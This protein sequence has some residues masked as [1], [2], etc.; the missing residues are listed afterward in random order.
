MLYDVGTLSAISYPVMRLA[1]HIEEGAGMNDQ[2]KTR[3]IQTKWIG[4]RIQTET[5]V[6]GTVYYLICDGCGCDRHFHA[7]PE[8]GRIAE[9]AAAHKRTCCR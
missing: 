5:D 7:M 4:I 9:F 3:S 1:T 6:S 8:D 2:N